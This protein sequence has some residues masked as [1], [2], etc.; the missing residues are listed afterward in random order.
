MKRNKSIC[1]P[2]LHV[3]LG[4]QLGL[5]PWSS[6]RVG[7][8]SAG[9][10]RTRHSVKGARLFGRDNR[11]QNSD[12]S[13]CR[14]LSGV[15]Q[16]AFLPSR[17]RATS[18]SRFA[19]LWI[20]NGTT[21]SVRQHL[22]SDIGCCGSLLERVGGG[23]SCRQRSVCT[24]PWKLPIPNTPKKPARRSFKESWFCG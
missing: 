10:E 20:S 13:S 15:R 14:E 4:E 21:T 1:S 6:D 23:S 9:A 17:Y 2:W 19:R 18:R 7:G 16:G 22:R 11:K 12:P 3:R 5:S 24:E 8:L